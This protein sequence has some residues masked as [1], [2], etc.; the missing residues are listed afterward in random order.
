MR[1]GNMKL[2]ISDI[3]SWKNFFDLIFDSC[4]I[5]ELKL[6]QDKCKMTVL[7]NGHVAYYDAEYSK[8]FFDVVMII[9]YVAM[10]AFGLTFVIEKITHKIKSKNK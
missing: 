1:N 10:L 6:D 9:G 7:N 4:S 2:K 3:N 5:V 8:E